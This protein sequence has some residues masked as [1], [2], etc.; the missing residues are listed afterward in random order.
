M[1]KSK[2]TSLDKLRHRATERFTTRLWF[3]NL[4]ADCQAFVS[5]SCALYY[6]KDSM[7]PSLTKLYQIVMEILAED[8]PDDAE[9]IP[10]E[11]TFRSWVQQQRESGMWSKEKT[12]SQ[13]ASMKKQA[14]SKRRMV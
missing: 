7:I 14:V 1:A 2:Q 11:R 9:I 12:Q 4:S 8:F 3:T 6:S 10:A 13:P 5:D